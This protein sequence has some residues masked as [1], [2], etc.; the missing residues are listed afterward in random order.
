MGLDGLRADEQ[1]RGDVV[2]ALSLRKQLQDLALSLGEV[3]EQRHGVALLLAFARDLGEQSRQRRRIDQHLAVRGG[4]RRAQDL[5][6]GEVLRQEPRGAG[7]DG[8]DHQAILVVRRHHDDL[9]RGGALLDPARGLDARH[10]RALEHDVHQHHVGQLLGCEDDAF[11][12]RVD[13]RADE[14]Q[15][16]VDAD[17]HRQRVGQNLVV[18]ADQQRHGRVG[19]QLI[20][21]SGRRICRMVPP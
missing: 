13:R 1:L 12:G 7:L 9:G 18:V 16:R 8:L 17:D 6:R 20:S 21:S 5:I 15:R 4:L 10:L 2:V 19:H 14:A 11:L 3:V